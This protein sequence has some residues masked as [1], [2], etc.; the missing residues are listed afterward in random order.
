MMYAIPFFEVLENEEYT[1]MKQ[2][3]KRLFMNKDQQKPLIYKS[4]RLNMLRV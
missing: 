1:E 4:G 3:I 2:M